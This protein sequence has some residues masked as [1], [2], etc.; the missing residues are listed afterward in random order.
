M[1]LQAS[2]AIQ[3]SDIIAEI[4]RAAGTPTSLGEG[5]NRWLA[6]VPSGIIRL[7]DFYSQRALKFTDSA[8]DTTSGSSFSFPL[9][10]GTNFTGRELVICFAGYNESGNTMTL[11]SLTVNGAALSVTQN[12]NYGSV[13]A[14]AAIGNTS[15]PAGTTITVAGVTANAYSRMY[16]AVIVGC[17][18]SATDDTAS[19]NGVATS[20]STSIT[21][22]ANGCVVQVTSRYTGGSDPITPAGSLVDVVDGA[23]GNGHVTIS[24]M[25]RQSASA[26]TIGWSGGSSAFRYATV[27]RAYH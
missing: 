20:A 17:N 21:P 19:I 7:S 23:F 14:I 10:V 4:D 22:G 15:V 2:G 13:G 3:I 8:Q 27:A 12:A 26:K 6:G 16:C 9:T 25:N 11:S 1:T 5:I 24:L 18:W